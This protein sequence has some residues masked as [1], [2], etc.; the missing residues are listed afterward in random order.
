MLFFIQK[1]K[2]NLKKKEPKIKLYCL[3]LY[4]PE[5]LKT[6]DANQT[7]ETFFQNLINPCATLLSRLGGQSWYHLKIILFNFF[8]LGNRAAF[9]YV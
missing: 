9:I 5:K 3:I 7:S 8:P 4:V 6:D 1:V 2:E